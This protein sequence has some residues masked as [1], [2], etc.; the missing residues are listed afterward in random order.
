MEEGVHR[1]C[2][3]LTFQPRIQASLNRTLHAWN[4]HGIRTKKNKTPVAIYELSRQ[5]AITRGY[6]TGDPGDDVGIIQ[7]DPMYGVDQ[8][9]PLPP[10]A[11]CID[12]PEPGGAEPGD[13][14]SQRQ[15][16][17]FINLD[18]E[19]DTVQE[20]MASFDWIREDSNWGIGVYVEAVIWLETLLS[21]C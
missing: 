20:I 15:S 6:W 16:G 14:V 9:G 5:K 10:A 13:P 17:I 7:F 2:L 3:F 18:D 12:D 19:L 11:E 8:Q 21:G 1:T 4:H